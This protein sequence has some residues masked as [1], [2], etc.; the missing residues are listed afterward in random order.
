MST[1]DKPDPARA[2]LFLAKLVAEDEAKRIEG[3][4][5]EEF[6]AEQ[7]KKGHDALRTPS[8]QEL[9]ER[10][11][12]LAARQE[13]A[14]GGGGEKAVASVPPSRPV[15]P[16]VPIRR[17]RIAWLLVA[18]L[19][20]AAL[21]AL[22]RPS[23][24]ARLHPDHGK[25]HSDD[26]QAPRPTR[27]EAADLLRDE[28]LDLCGKAAWVEC[29]DELDEAARLDPAGESEPRVQKARAD[30]LS[31]ERPGPNAPQTPGP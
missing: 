4:S 29:K 12:V 28:A 2:A 13:P 22:T 27:H 19:A 1:T 5:D 3:L 10:M 26:D 17:S 16:V 31:A 15:A 24:V 9:L 14:A 11:K 6:Q 8:T 30:I 18:A 25:S 23:T 7:K 21:F 20:I